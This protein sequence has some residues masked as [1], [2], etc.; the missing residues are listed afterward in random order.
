MFTKQQSIIWLIGVTLGL[1]GGGAA[2]GLVGPEGAF[3][4]AGVTATMALLVRLKK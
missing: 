2:S 3:I 1:L 4:A